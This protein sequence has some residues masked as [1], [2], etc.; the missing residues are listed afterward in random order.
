MSHEQIVAVVDRLSRETTDLAV[1]GVKQ[2]IPVYEE[3]HKDGK[4]DPYMDMLDA[5]NSGH[6]TDVLPGV[7]QYKIRAL[8]NLIKKSNALGCVDDALQG[9]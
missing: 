5:F 8:E 2:L 3:I 7:N 1:K 9:K 4:V 6:A